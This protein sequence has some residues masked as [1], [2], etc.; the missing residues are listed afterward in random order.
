MAMKSEDDQTRD[1]CIEVGRTLLMCG[2]VEKHVKQLSRSLKFSEWLDF[3]E[4]DVN[5]HNA[6]EKM[7]KNYG[8]N[9]EFVR[10]LHEFRDNRNK[11]V[12]ETWELSSS[13]LNT[14]EGRRDAL[15]FIVALYAMASVLNKL[16]YP[17][18]MERLRVAG[19]H[20]PDW[21]GSLLSMT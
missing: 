11:F 13:R 3:K 14:E 9:D 8:L 16:L 19:K 4:G 7:K 12:H 18:V 2:L 10:V 6:I 15:S 5:F 21:G 1:F 20:P 17:H